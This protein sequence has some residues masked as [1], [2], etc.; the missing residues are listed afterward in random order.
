LGC[1]S[2]YV[3]WEHWIGTMLFPIALVGCHGARLLLVHHRSDLFAV[4][5]S[6]SRTGGQWA[7]ALGV[8]PCTPVTYGNPMTSHVSLDRTTISS[9]PFDFPAAPCLRVMGTAVAGPLPHCVYLE[10]PYTYCSGEPLTYGN[11]R[12][13]VCHVT[14]LTLTFRVDNCTHCHC[15]DC[16]YT[17]CI[18]I[19]CASLAQYAYFVR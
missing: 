13:H 4:F 19:V 9:S 7:T 5:F 2:L 17:F 6:H 16:T 14:G 11:F 15:G 8:G 10:S 18:C 3:S 12:P 1:A